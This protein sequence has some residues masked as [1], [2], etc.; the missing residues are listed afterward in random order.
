M[1][2]LATLPAVSDM[3]C[4]S[5]RPSAAERATRPSC[6]APGPERGVRLASST[7]FPGLPSPSLLAT[8]ISRCTPRIFELRPRYSITLP[9]LLQPSCVPAP[10]PTPS[11]FPTLMQPTATARRRQS[12]CAPATR[13]RIYE[14]LHHHVQHVSLNS[15]PISKWQAMRMTVH[16]LSVM[17]NGSP[18]LPTEI[19][20]Q[21]GGED[22]EA[23]SAPCRRC[24]S[25]A[26]LE[27]RRM[28]A[29]PLMLSLARSVLSI[30]FDTR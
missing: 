27:P 3:Q 11:R 8:T 30:R 5:F 9:R 21:G 2:W 4:S 29:T 23:L 10:S 28:S 18:T 13:G 20:A 12:S 15:W 24:G 19:R 22:L 14:V 16:T 17:P 7:R 1:R 25:R 6:C 26:D